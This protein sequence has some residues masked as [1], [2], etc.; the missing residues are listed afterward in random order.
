MILDVGI[1]EKKKGNKISDLR[2]LWN[3]IPTLTLENLLFTSE[4]CLSDVQ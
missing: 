3:Q 2:N 1:G 4:N